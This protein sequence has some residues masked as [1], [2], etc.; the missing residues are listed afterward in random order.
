[1]KGH[2]VIRIDGR[3]VPDRAAL[4]SQLAAALKFPSYFGGNLD[5]LHDCLN[6]LEQY[7]PAPGYLVLVE[8]ADA[9]CPARR[10]DFTAVIEVLEEAVAQRRAQPEAKPL[11]VEVSA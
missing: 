2:L 5:A 8:H 6:D 10:E 11:R 4:L 7:S 3:A 1:M 9:A